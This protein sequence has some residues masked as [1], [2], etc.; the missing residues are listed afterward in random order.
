MAVKNKK[1]QDYRY[2]TASNVSPVCTIS[3]A[4]TSVFDATLLFLN[5]KMYI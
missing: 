5:H 4:K 3:V 2:K 1:K